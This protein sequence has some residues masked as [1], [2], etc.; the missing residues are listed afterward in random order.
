[1][2]ES[3]QIGNVT[4]F[5]QDGAKI[6]KNLM[7][8]FNEYPTDHAFVAATCSVVCT[9]ISAALVKKKHSRVLIIILH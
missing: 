8:Y 1:M 4:E 5:L 2:L 3:S 7:G 9:E 6:T